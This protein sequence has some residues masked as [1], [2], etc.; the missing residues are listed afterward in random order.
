LASLAR[1]DRKLDAAKA[2]E[3]R[4]G[5]AHEAF[6]CYLALPDAGRTIS[7]WKV[8]G[9]VRREHTDPRDV[10]YWDRLIDGLCK[11]GMAE[12]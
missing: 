12:E 4:Q 8:E 9:S 10:E 5:R 7:A 2:I 3:A 11:A 1:P 6:Q